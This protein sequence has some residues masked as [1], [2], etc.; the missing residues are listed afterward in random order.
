MLLIRDEDGKFVRPRPVFDLSGHPEE[1]IATKW[2]IRDLL[3][4]LDLDIDLPHIVFEEV[5]Y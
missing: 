1:E 2:G 5:V 3:N 4:P